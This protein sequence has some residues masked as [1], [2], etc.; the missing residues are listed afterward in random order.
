M[1]GTKVLHSKRCRASLKWRTQHGPGQ[2]TEA[3]AARAQDAETNE[4]ATVQCGQQSPR[5][6]HFALDNT[7]YRS[8]PEQQAAIQS[9]LRWR[10]RRRSIAL[11]QGQAQPASLKHAA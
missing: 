6:D 1:R 2:G 11:K 8:H 9:Y 3:V 5:A 7:D 4:A 10:N